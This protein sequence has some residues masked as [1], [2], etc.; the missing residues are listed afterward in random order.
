MI[1]ELTIDS[2][3]G[4]Y[5]EEDCI[6]IIEFDTNDT[7]HCLNQFIIDSIKFGHDHL[8]MFFA[9]REP[10]P[11]TAKIKFYEEHFDISLGEVFPLPKGLQLFFLYDFG[12]EWIFKVKK[13]R[14][15]PTAPI[16]D[17]SYPR[18]IKEIGPNPKQY[19]DWEDEE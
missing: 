11:R 16:K 12:D 18:I 19:G 6:K 9:G 4:A 7:L 17:I 8:T 15:K 13:S 5:W 3:T 1:V 10:I 2:Y 14:K